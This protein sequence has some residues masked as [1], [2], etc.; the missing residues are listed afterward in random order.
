M[1]DRNFLNGQVG[2]E[3]LPLEH[4]SIER[5]STFVEDVTIRLIDET[6]CK[7]PKQRKR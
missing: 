1:N 6:D 3:H 7:D 2:M 4:S 5:H